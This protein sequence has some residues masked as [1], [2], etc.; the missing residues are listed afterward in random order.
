MEILAE[1]IQ[2]KIQ[3]IHRMR[4][5]SVRGRVNLDASGRTEHR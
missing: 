3:C 4:A 5:G 2:E 1:G